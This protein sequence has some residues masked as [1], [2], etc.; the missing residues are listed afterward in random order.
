MLISSH[1]SAPQLV[2]SVFTPRPAA[3]VILIGNR[4]V[5]LPSSPNRTSSAVGPLIE[6]KPFERSCESCDFCP[7]IGA[8]CG[9]RCECS[10]NVMCRLNHETSCSHTAGVLHPG[11]WFVSID[12]P[13]SFT[14]EANL[15]SALALQSDLRAIRRTVFAVGGRGGAA[16]FATGTS[17]GVA[18]S[19]YFFFDPAPHQSSRVA[20]DLLRSGPGGGW[21]DVYMRFGAW[22]TIAEHD[23]VV[24]CDAATRPNG[25]FVLQADRLLSQRVHLMVI[26]RGNSWSQYEI[27]ATNVLSTP[28][29]LLLSFS[30][31]AGCV[32][33]G[34]LARLY[35]MRKA[36]KQPAPSKAALKPTRERASSFGV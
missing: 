24:S 36:R 20:I 2:V 4:A 14:L 26:A 31:L 34:V 35:W 32:A 29:V 16:A 8:G 1:L 13:G 12:T 23:A 10:C 3:D 18:F 7:C 27:S 22:P 11:R 15:E 28:F 17:E 19:D 33:I 30:L 6:I 5:A 9:S 25:Q 21:V